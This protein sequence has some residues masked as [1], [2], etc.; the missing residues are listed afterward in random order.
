MNEYLLTITV[1]GAIALAIVFV[2]IVLT[3]FFRA[4]AWT[5]GIDARPQPLA[6]RGVL[7]RESLVTVHLANGKTF[8]SVR[9]IGFTSAGN[10]KTHL[11][12]ELNGMVI[13]E[14]QQKQQYLIRAKNIQM[15][16]V[17]PSPAP[18]HS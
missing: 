11:P 8:D 1:V 16:V 2:V 3:L 7:K 10:P 17:A 4:L 5:S 14:D 13:L 9:F 6:V 15:I 18:P 12:F